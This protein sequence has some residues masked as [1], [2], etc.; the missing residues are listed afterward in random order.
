MEEAAFPY[1]H[2][3]YMAVLPLEYRHLIPWQ[4]FVQLQPSDLVEGIDAAVVPYWHTNYMAVLPLDSRHILPNVF[5]QGEPATFVE[6]DDPTVPYWHVNYMA[7]LP[8][9]NRYQLPYFFTWLD[10]SVATAGLL[11]TLRPRTLM[12]IMQ[13]RSLDATMREGGREGT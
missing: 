10:I 9:E 4:P 6:P 12:P 2:T 8:V 5:I 3:N 11:V 13:A 1:W 7:V